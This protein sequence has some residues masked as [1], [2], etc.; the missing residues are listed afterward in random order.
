MRTQST[1]S[2]TEADTT[3][4]QKQNKKPLSEQNLMGTL[5]HQ[6]SHEKRAIY[7]QGYNIGKLRIDMAL[8][9]EYSKKLAII[10][11]ID[12]TVLDSGPHQALNIRTGQSYPY[13]WDKWVENGKSEALPGAID[14]LTYADSKNISIFYF[15][16]RKY[17]QTD[18][19]IR[20]LQYIGAPQANAEHVLLQERGGKNGRFEKIAETHEILLFFGDNLSD[21][22]KFYGKSNQEIN[23]MV[24]ENKYLFGD[25]LIIFPNPM[26]GDWE[27]ILY[28][29]DYDLPDTVKREI[30]YN[31]LK[32]FEYEESGS[33]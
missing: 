2:L 20:S 24:E 16:N 4:V 25:K 14:F 18:A 19:T 5:W 13:H 31:N 22:P 21:F 11:D 32:Y 12:E 29:H 33:K 9:K 26:Y 7:Y 1:I 28:H 27:G 23:D 8:T 3:R 17:S 15:S 6:A 30:R 10:M